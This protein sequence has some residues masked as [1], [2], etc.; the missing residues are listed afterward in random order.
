V[1]ETLDGCLRG[2]QGELGLANAIGPGKGDQSLGWIPKVAEKR[3]LLLLAIDIK[4]APRRK[5]VLGRRVVK[6]RNVAGRVGA[7]QQGFPRLDALVEKP[8][9]YGGFN[10]QLLHKHTATGLILSQC[11]TTLSTESEEQH[12]L[13]MGLLLPRSELKQASGGVDSRQIATLI[14][15][16]RDEAM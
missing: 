2:G 5:V 15:V 7:I 3:S 14:R 1:L 10:T 9:L 13:S 12:K 6:E 16:V 8:G 11:R 4:G